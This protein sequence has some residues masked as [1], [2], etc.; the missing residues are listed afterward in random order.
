MQHYYITLTALTRNNI[1]I[2]ILN[3]KAFPSLVALCQGHAVLPSGLIAWI[4]A[5]FPRAG[6]SSA[7]A[8][9]AARDT[10]VQMGVFPRAYAAALPSRS[11]AAK[12]VLHE[13]F[14][15]SVA[16]GSAARDTLVQMD[17]FPLAYAA[18]K[19]MRC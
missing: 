4:Y 17:A 7:A 3:T 11:C 2:K 8:G 16:A 14:F 19:V 15:S 13:R 5:A 1:L 18:V 6:F 10:V 9:S 12:A